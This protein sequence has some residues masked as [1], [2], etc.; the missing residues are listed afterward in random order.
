MKNNIIM[1]INYAEI[2][3]G[4]GSYGKRSIDDVCAF[5]AGLGFAGIEF[6]GVVPHGMEISFR[7]YAE[8][9]AE[10]KKK[11]GLSEI[12]FGFGVADC[13][14]RDSAKRDAAIENTVERAKIARE[15]CGVEVCNTNASWIGA[16][17]PNT[18]WYRYDLCG[19]AAAEEED[20]K[21]TADSFA[22][23]AAE[24]ER[25]GMRF[26]FETH[27]GYVHDLPDSARRLV[28]TIASPAL[29]INLDY[30]NTVYFK[31]R[32][33]LEEAID[34]CGDKLFYVH[35][36]NSVALP[37]TPNLQLATALGEGQ[38]DHRA[39][40][41]KLCAVGYEGPI[42]IEAPRQGDR[43]WYAKCDM[44]YMKDLLSDFA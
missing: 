6:R 19:S 39:Y 28:D 44:A 8:K 17:V 12:M 3:G 27:M 32:P 11:N 2:P 15:V 10:G 16:K 4:K 25:I 9:I 42:G 30:G 18:P 23:I 24:L 40:M 22:R 37:E 33:S 43:I 29:G 35:M 41:N 1:Q 14:N 20:W 38:I 7:E 21:L 26:A 31:E 34:L 36:K 13:A 5:A